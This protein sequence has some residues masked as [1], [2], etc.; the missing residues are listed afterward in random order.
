MQSVA[1]DKV[2]GLI[3]GA[4]DVRRLPDA[5]QPD[6]LQPIRVPAGELGLYDPFTRYVATMPGGARLRMRTDSTCIGL[7]LSE[8]RIAGPPD[9]RAAWYDLFVDGER[10]ARQ[11][12]D[13]GAAHDLE[14]NR[15]DG[16][17]AASVTFA[18]LPAADK[19]VELWLPQFASV[20]IRAL[21][22]DDG[23]TLRP[24]PDLRQRIVF[25]GSSIT[26]CAEAAGPSDAWPAVA[27]RLANV[28]HLN[29]GWAGSCL[30]SGL[31]ARIIRDTPANAI[32]LKLG[33]NV[34]DNAALQE[35][36][37]VDSAHA[38]LAIVREKHPR[39]PVALVSPIISPPRET[40]SSGGG[41]PLVR[42]RSL[43][44]D[45]AATWQARGDSQ[46]HYVSGLDL[47]GET[48]LGDLPDQLHPNAAGYVRM[49]ERFH[50]LMLAPGKPL[51]LPR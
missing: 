44:Q 47:F 2:A 23:A 9:T 50:A 24:W 26:H 28:R 5:Q 19:Q 7:D 17:D 42:M 4:V 29:L 20:R 45:V 1:L 49:G 15:V 32:V 34:S 3:D 18:G 22:I 25:H 21:H 27:A 51:G 36:T 38:M 41:L 48:D 35:R 40:S 8:R 33:I 46:L 31:A 16:D 10:V 13:G 30:L 39:V 6:A 37:F 11:R 12:A 43:L 14:T